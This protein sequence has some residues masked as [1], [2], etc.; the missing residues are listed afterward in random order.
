MA[1]VRSYD[2]IGILGNAMGYAMLRHEVLADNIANIDTPGFKRSDVSF[3]YEL[4]RALDESPRIE[5]QR[6][7]DRHFETQPP[8][9]PLRVKPKVFAELDTWSRNDKNNVDPEV[10]MS[11]LAE[12]TLYY[13]VLVNR[14]SDTMR[15]LR[16]IVTRTPTL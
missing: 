6:T 3:Q 4:Q 10:E 13:Q 1:R 12:N 11:R 14:M 16:N 9:D 2:N 8:H 7:S 15:N 5:M